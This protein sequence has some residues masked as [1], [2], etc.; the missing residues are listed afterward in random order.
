MHLKLKQPVSEVQFALAQAAWAAFR[1][2]TPESWAAFLRY[3]TSALPFLRPAILRHLEEYPAPRTGL[4]RTEAF[5]LEMVYTG[6]CHA[7]GAVPFVR[8][9]GG[10]AFMGDWSFWRILDALT[11][12]AAPFL[13][14]MRFPLSRP[15]SAKRTAP[16]ISAA[17]SS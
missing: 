14:G 1:A 3:E 5:I 16:P 10:S 9:E 17:N 6:A 11:H 2:P 13:T 4:T 12:G 15:H 7:D 8:R